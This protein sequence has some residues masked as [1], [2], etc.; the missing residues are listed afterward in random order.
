MSGFFSRVSRYA[1]PPGADQRNQR[2]NRL[3]GI[4]A[5]VL[6][7][8]R[9]LALELA[10]LWL[11]LRHIDGQEEKMPPWSSTRA[12]LDVDGLVLRLPVSTWR[13]TRGG[14][15]PDIELR[16]GRPGASSADDIVV[17]VEVKHGSPP[18]KNQLQNYLDDAS[19]E[20]AKATAVVLLAPRASYPFPGLVPPGVPE[21]TWQD[22][23][24]ECQRWAPDTEK[25]RFLRDEFLDYL[26]EESLMEPKVFTPMHL[27]ALAEYN[28]MIDGIARVC[29]LASGY[30]DR[31]W[32]TRIDCDNPHGKE[33]WGVGYW[34]TIPPARRGQE[35][36]DWSPAFWDWNLKESDLGMDDSHGGV[37][38]FTAGASAEPRNTI[39][40]GVEAAAWQAKL[41]ASNDF[42]YFRDSDGYDRFV[43]VAYP[44]EVLVGRDLSR[45]A[46]SLGKWVVD[47]YE[48]LYEAGRP[49]G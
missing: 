18:G 15:F 25:A 13:L 38:V 39:I 19:Q 12:A 7:Q 4:F 32:N 34:E 47:T 9:G 29:E 36:P 44:E 3:T 35:A 10:R 14:N 33:A 1:G 48:A 17:W 2:E 49:P 42:V 28:R 20:E 23:A 16:F 31:N 27:A 46:D 11:A 22:T 26:Q 40:R 24:H 43:R 8:T 30:I 5:A 21:C 6:E 41:Q 45:Q 37:P